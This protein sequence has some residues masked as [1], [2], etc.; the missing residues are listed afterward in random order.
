MIKETQYRTLLKEFNKSGEITMSSRK[1][2]MS[3]KTGSNYLGNR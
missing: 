1:S 2:G 3:Q